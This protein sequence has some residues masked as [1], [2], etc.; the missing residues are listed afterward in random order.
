MVGS[1]PLASS[2]RPRK[3]V[4]PELRRRFRPKTM[5]PDEPHGAGFAC[6]RKNIRSARIGL[7][8]LPFNQLICTS[9]VHRSRR[10]GYLLLPL[11]PPPSKF[12]ARCSLLMLISSAFL[13]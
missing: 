6:S 2:G 12:V 11:E 1:D 5:R 9:E 8:D 10:L 7:T 13:A 3:H 4:Q